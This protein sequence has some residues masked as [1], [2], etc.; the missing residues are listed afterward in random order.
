MDTRSTTTVTTEVTIKKKTEEIAMLPKMR[1]CPECNGPMEFRLITM[2]AEDKHLEVVIKIS[3]VPALVC[4]ECGFELVSMQTAKSLDALVDA[5]F[6]SLRKQ[7]SVIKTFP[8]VNIGF[9][10]DENALAVA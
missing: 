10:F 5:I 7:Q 6:D 1:S 3:G 9:D 4:K 8:K 2:N